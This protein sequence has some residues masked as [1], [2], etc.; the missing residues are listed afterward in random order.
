M[1]NGK[2]S[3]GEIVP[4]AS[5]QSPSCTSFANASRSCASTSGGRVAGKSAPAVASAV[6]CPTNVVHAASPVPGVGPG[7][8]MQLSFAGSLSSARKSTIENGA[9]GGR[10]A[11]RAVPR[12]TVQKE[13]SG[14]AQEDTLER[15]CVVEEQGQVTVDSSPALSFANSAATFSGDGEMMVSALMT[16]TPTISRRPSVT[17]KAATMRAM[18]DSVSWR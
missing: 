7:A 10:P 3:F 5:P 1:G 6:T 4:K 13:S 12:A 11:K 2:N 14:K 16:G 17:R 9:T 15:L 8:P 18:R